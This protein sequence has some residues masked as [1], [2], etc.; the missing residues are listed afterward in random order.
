[1]K[2]ENTASHYLLEGLFAGEGVSFTAAVTR[3][4][5]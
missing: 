2:E 1:M 5:S 4:I 3:G